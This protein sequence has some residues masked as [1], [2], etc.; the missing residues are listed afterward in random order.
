MFASKASAI[1]STSE[2]GFQEHGLKG[3]SIHICRFVECFINF[4]RPA[5][6]SFKNLSSSTKDYRQ[7]LDS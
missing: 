2:V 7:I 6:A 5:L 3:T 4:E 1:S